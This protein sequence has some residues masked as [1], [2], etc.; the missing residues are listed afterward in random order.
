MFPLFDR[1]PTSRFPFLTVI[2]IIANVAIAFWSTQLSFKE[3]IDIA[4]EYGLVPQRLS[5]INSGQPLAIAKELTDGNVYRTQLATDPQFVLPSLITMMFLH[6]GWLHV[7]TNM[8]MLW[9]FGNNVEDRLGSFFFGVFYLLGGI[10]SGCCQWAIDPTSD[11]PV[12]GASGAVWAVLAGYAVT[13][14][15]AKILT[16]V[17]VGIPLLLNLP[18]LLVIAVCFAGDLAMGLWMLQGN[19]PAQPIAHWAHI[20]GAVAGVIFMPLLGLGAE[21]PD[22]DWRNESKELLSPAKMET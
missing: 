5:Q 7:I 3:G 19:A 20:G 17:F 21:P 9:V 4:H 11:M 8:W 10:A 18:A 6:G 13:Y 12:V 14:P 2:L 1:L 16:L 22:A 15:K